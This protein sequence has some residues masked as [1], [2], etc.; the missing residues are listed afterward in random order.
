MQETK[1]V[2]HTK[3]GDITLIFFPEV[4]P[5]HTYSFIELSKKKFYDKTIFHRI[6]PGFMIQ[7][8]DP[9]SKSTDRSRHGT[10]DPGYKL[11]AEFSKMEHR[12]GTLSMAR[13][14]H[15]DSAGSQFF[16]CV[17]N[18]PHLDGKYT[19]F[20]RVTE[21]MDVVDKIVRQPRDRRDNPIDRIEMKVEVVVPKGH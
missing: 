3:F 19:V 7:G 6:I 4:A 12:R 11:K 17:A 1:A 15:P 16:I 13:S 20:G 8:G 14:R 9:I 5:N 21:G 10:G 18:A 2:I